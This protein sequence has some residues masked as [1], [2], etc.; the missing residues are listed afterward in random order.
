MTSKFLHGNTVLWFGIQGATYG[1]GSTCNGSTTWRNLAIYLSILALS[2][3]G[4]PASGWAQSATNK[5]DAF[6]V[7]AEPTSIALTEPSSIDAARLAQRANQRDNQAGASNGALIKVNAD[8]LRTQALAKNN[9]I[10]LPLLDKGQQTIQIETIGT[11]PSGSLTVTGVLTSDPQSRVLLVLTKEGITQATVTHGD[12]TYELRYRDSDIHTLSEVDPMRDWSELPPLERETTEDDYLDNLPQSA[13][14]QRTADDGSIIDVMVLYT[15]AVG[16]ETGGDSAMRASIELAVLST[17]V[18]YLNSNVDHNI[19]LVHTESVN[20]DASRGIAA[21]LADLTFHNAAFNGTLDEIHSIRDAKGADIVVMI[22]EDRDFC[23]RA[24]VMTAIDVAFADRAFAVVSN[25][26]LLDGRSFAHEIGH[27]MGLAHNREAGNSTGVF[28]DSYGYTD[29]AGQWRTIMSYNTCPNGPCISLNYYSNPL[30]FFQGTAMGVLAPSPIAADNVR[31]L[32]TT[33]STVANFRV[34]VVDTPPTLVLPVPG[35]SLSGANQKFVWQGGDQ[36]VDAWQLWLG[37]TAGASDLFDSGIVTQVYAN[38]GDLPTNGEKVHATLRYRSNSVWS[39][40]EDVYLAFNNGTP[41]LL[42]P[43]P[44]STLT[45]NSAVFDWV[46]GGANIN[47]WTVRIYDPVNPAAGNFFEQR[48]DGSVTQVA[49]AG[50]PTDGRT[51]AVDLIYS[52]NGL[53]TTTQSYI[54]TTQSL[55]I[56]E[57]IISSPLNDSTIGEQQEFVISTGGNDLAEWRLVVK[58]DSPFSDSTIADSGWTNNKNVILT[59]WP[60]NGDTVYLLFDCQYKNGAK[61]RRDFY[62]YQTQKTV[63]TMAPAVTAPEPDSQLAAKTAQ[64][65]W[66]ANTTDVDRWRIKVGDRE[67]SNNYSESQWLDKTVG[68]T[69]ASGW[70]T[71]GSLVYITLEYII[72]GQSRPEQVSFTYRA[73]VI[74]PQLTIEDTRVNEGAGSVD[75]TIT[76]T[77]ANAAGSVRVNTTDLTAQQG[78]DYQSVDKRVSFAA[79]E[80]SQVV[81]ISIIDDAVT[82]INERFEVALTDAVSMQITR[83]KAAVDIIDN[84]PVLPSG[85]NKITATQFVLPTTFKA[86]GDE[87][88]IDVSVTNDGDRELTGIVVNNPMTGGELC[89]ISRLWVGQTAQCSTNYTIN[90]TDVARG[91]VTFDSTITADQLVDTVVITKTVVLDDAEPPLPNVDSQVEMT[92][93][94]DPEEYSRVGETLSYVMTLNNNGDTALTGLSITDSILGEPVCELQSLWQDTTATCEAAYVVTQE[95]IDRGEIVTQTQVQTQQTDTPQTVTTRAT[96][97]A[98]GAPPL[99]ARANLVVQVSPSEYSSVGEELTLLLT[100]QNIGNAPLTDVVV[101]GTGDGDLMCEVGELYTNT[102]TQCTLVYSVD[103]SDMQRGHL[104][105]AARLNAKQLGV[106]VVAAAG[107]S[108]KSNP[109]ENAAALTDKKDQFK[110]A[111]FTSVSEFSKVGDVVETLYTVTNT[112]SDTLKDI[113]V[114]QQRPGGGLRSVCSADSLAPGIELQCTSTSSISQEDMDNEAVSWRAIVDTQRFTNGASTSLRLL[115]ANVD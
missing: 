37:T 74:V 78:T 26:C 86:Y 105:I 83:A 114:W 56:T 36:Q 29:P 51:I 15:N 94:L 70:P 58:E 112:T 12:S 14:A 44:G 79:G 64:V 113:Q 76:R 46:S 20:Y 33:S 7:V 101:T 50:W 47:H 110:I 13:A 111:G 40:I 59:G 91:S 11:T 35:E 18:G 62:Q 82:E 31:T 85:E 68:S 99:N 103:S 87:L 108:K 10:Q 73:P 107:A 25:D 34:S 109:D 89:T 45:G 6:S 43:T 16:R 90:E 72:T 28:D 5:N 30:V 39:T 66:T 41:E 22:T 92:I 17:N 21:S 53:K 48:L 63:S 97:D 27:T 4:F 52:L 49:A 81:S 93:D 2:Y 42:S 23:G 19:R 9:R 104:N 96:Y 38:A 106:A 61:C 80:L 115:R 102:G 95:D 98:T 54:Y 55:S 88:Q 67:F 60:N 8:A 32:N 65:F 69:T 84:D 100:V 71:D 75:V 3:L 24:W 1:S 77:E 57:A